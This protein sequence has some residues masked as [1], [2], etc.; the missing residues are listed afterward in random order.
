[1]RGDP[2]FQNPL[3]GKAAVNLRRFFAD[4]IFRVRFLAVSKTS[5]D[6]ADPPAVCCGSLNALD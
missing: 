4:L 2:A 1:M 5:G 3:R 6:F